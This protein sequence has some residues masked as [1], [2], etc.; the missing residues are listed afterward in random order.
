MPPAPGVRSS[1]LAEAEEPSACPT[2]LPIERIPDPSRPRSTE[3]DAGGGRV[4]LPITRA[5]AAAAEPPSAAARPSAA[6]PPSARS[7]GCAREEEEEEEEV[8]RVGEPNLLRAGLRPPPITR[9]RLADA[10][11]AP[12]EVTIDAPI[13][14]PIRESSDVLGGAIVSPALPPA[15]GSCSGARGAGRRRLD[16]PSRP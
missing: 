16:E 11:A 12:I 15:V 2:C 8:P 9:S 7:P 3:G 14:A 10:E 6:A 13:R 4:G 1:L 5:V